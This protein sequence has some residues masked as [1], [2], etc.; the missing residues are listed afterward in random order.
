MSGGE[1]HEV[2]VSDYYKVVA[3]DGSGDYTSIQEAI[4]SSKA[5]PYQRVIIKVKNGVYREK[6]KVYAWNP[7]IS[8][9]GEDKEK[10]IITYDDHFKKI[11]LGRNS[12]FHTATLS[13]EGC[14]FYASNLTIRNTAGDVGQA[15]ALSV[16]ANKVMI[17]NCNIEGNQD[18]LY[19]SG[20]GFR[21]YYHKCYI[22]GTTDF[23]FGN[24]TALFSNCTIHSKADS[25][26][27]AASTPQHEPFGYAF[28]H[29][30]LTADEHVSKVYLGRPW[31]KYAKTVFVETVI[32]D[33]VVEEGW[34]MWSGEEDNHAF[35]AEYKCTGPG[36]KPESRVGWS[37]QLD[38]LEVA[39]YT[40]EN[41]LG[42]GGSE[43]EDPWY[44]PPKTM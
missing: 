2:A 9:I 19:T 35:Y 7:N 27:T 17:E 28:A 20:E 16:S 32:G 33:H 24:A 22:E 15:I 43:S 44:L 41:I 8:L 30:T 23:I 12:T 42:T 38:S 34:S 31:R 39:K 3:R 6:V 29:C 1:C 25:Y 5:F 26:I 21:Q 11:D 13:V 18:T 10:T 4:N 14:S 37:H 40:I 36:F